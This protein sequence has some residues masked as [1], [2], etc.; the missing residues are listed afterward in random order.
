M[1]SCSR[2]RWSR[3]AD[4]FCSL[5]LDGEGHTVSQNAGR[6]GWHDMNTADIE[7]SADFY[8]RLFGWVASDH[9]MANG[10]R[11]LGDNHHAFGGLSP[12]P[13]GVQERS[14]WTGYLVVKDVVATAGRVI[15]GGGQVPFES[16]PIPGVGKLGIAIDPTGAAV[17]TFT[18]EPDM[19]RRELGTGGI[20]KTVLW[21]ELATT[22]LAL[23]AAFHRDVFGWTV[24]EDVV[25][26]RGYVIAK[27]DGCPVAGL[28][29]PS[30]AP[31]SS[32]WITYFRVADIDRVIEQALSLDARL[33]HDATEV[34]GIGKTAWLLAPNEAIF[35]LMQPT[36]G[37]YEGLG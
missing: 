12:W 26:A 3:A 4:Q 19:A 15:S 24:D 25:E 30:P 37:W 22:D 33:A 31:A 32:A 8:Q 34:P 9:V 14:H 10:Y 21:N 20:G 28:F 18:A 27:V 1:G 5:R 23:S 6:F 36:E 11:E 35:G 29:Q 16:M 17:T 2:L 13:E 7:R